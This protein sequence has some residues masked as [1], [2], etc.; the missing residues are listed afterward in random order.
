M[1]ASAVP[2]WAAEPG[3][4]VRPFVEGCYHGSPG[5]PTEP[6]GADVTAPL[7]KDRAPT[8]GTLH[9]SHVTHIHLG[10][11]DAESG[12]GSVY[13]FVVSWRATADQ[14][15]EDITCLG[16]LTHRADVTGWAARTPGGNLAGDYRITGYIEDNAGNRADIAPPGGWTFSF[17]PQADGCAVLVVRPPVTCV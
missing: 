8:P 1:A 11:T 13:E 2:A 16:F 7:L 10:S 14:D 12:V 4:L 3:P 17:D 5:E 9:A 6:S 15:W